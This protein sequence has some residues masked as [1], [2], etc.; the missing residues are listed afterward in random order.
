[1]ESHVGVIG[2]PNLPH[3]GAVGQKSAPC[4]GSRGSTFPILCL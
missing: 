1:M 3:V 4:W 2:A